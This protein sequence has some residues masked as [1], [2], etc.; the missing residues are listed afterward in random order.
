MSEPQQKQTPEEIAEKR[1]RQ[2][3]SQRRYH[4]RMVAANN[5]FVK[6][7]ADFIGSPTE[8]IP[9]YAARHGIPL[10]QG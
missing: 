10:Y 3:N 9:R 2:R 1:R 5:E 6:T 4:Q 7:L 8:E